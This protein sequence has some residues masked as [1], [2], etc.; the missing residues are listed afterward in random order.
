MFGLLWMI[1]VGPEAVLSDLASARSEKQAEN[2]IEQMQTAATCGVAGAAHFSRRRARGR[3]AR[4]PLRFR[5][6]RWRDEAG[7]THTRSEEHVNTVWLN[8]RNTP[9][10]D[11]GTERELARVTFVRE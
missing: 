10:V 11:V 2:R 7:R 8:R 5:T 6:C 3:R 1:G 4:L 9:A